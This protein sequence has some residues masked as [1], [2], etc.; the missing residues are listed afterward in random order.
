MLAAKRFGTVS[1]SIK[2][3]LALGHTI[4][5]LFGQKS[6]GESDKRYEK[7]IPS[8]PLWSNQLR[9][10]SNDLKQLKRKARK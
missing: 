5:S 2:I 9:A 4:N 1:V 7:I 8:I 10:T 6:D 3:A